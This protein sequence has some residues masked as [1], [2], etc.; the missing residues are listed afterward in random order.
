M[1]ALPVTLIGALLLVL[2][3][4][5]CSK[6]PHSL[7]GASAEP[8]SSRA[9]NNRL[10]RT[11]VSMNTRSRLNCRVLNQSSVSAHRLSDDPIII[12]CHHPDTVHPNR[13]QEYHLVRRFSIRRNLVPSVNWCT[14]IA[15]KDGEPKRQC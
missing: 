8:V 15:S 1:D 6:S 7:G 9:A 13:V 2:Q 5:C 3:R 14:V 10:G 4:C 11:A 12:R